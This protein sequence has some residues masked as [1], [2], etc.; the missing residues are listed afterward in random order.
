MII[1]MAIRIAR[2]MGIEAAIRIIGLATVLLFCVLIINLVEGIR[3]YQ[4]E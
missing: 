1:G 2:S 3:P 4:I